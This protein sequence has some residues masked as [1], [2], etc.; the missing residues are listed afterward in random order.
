MDMSEIVA[1]GDLGALKKI[2]G[3]V[4]DT[5]PV[6]VLKDPDGAMVMVRHR[7]PL[8]HTPF[9]LGEVYVT[10]CEVRVDGEFGY[11]CIVGTGVE[12]ALYGALLDA[13]SRLPGERRGGIEEAVSTMLAAE[14]RGIRRRW[15]EEAGR[16]ASTKVDFEVSQE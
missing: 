15:A 13:Y 7:D 5:L 4:A 6:D 8:E 14:E 9:Y 1:E 3:L 10:E 12:R 11:G 16:I 2:A